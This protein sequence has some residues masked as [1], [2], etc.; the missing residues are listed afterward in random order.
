MSERTILLIGGI[1]G[2]VAMTAGSLGA[3]GLERW[4]RPDAIDLFETGVRYHMFHALAILAAV[5]FVGRFRLVTTIAVACFVIGTLI[6]SGSMYAL[7][8]HEARWLG[9]TAAFGGVFLLM[10]WGALVVGFW[11]RGERA[12]VLLPASDPPEPPSGPVC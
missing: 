11:I 3:H 6:F 1:M 5:G 7:A 2:I 8:M 12:F 4:I 9:A 10:G